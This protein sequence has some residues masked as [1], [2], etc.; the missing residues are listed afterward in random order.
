MRPTRKL[1]EQGQSLWLDTITREQY[2]AA[3]NAYLRGIEWRIEAG[4]AP[5]AASSFITRRDSAVRDNV[6][7]QISNQLGIAIGTRIC[8]AYRGPRGECCLRFT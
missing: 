6:P 8:K 3:V 1:H 4:L 5:A 2:L 7:E